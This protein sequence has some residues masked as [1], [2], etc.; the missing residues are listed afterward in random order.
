[1]AEAYYAFNQE[2]NNYYK[3]EKNYNETVTFGF[4]FAGDLDF[5]LY[6]PVH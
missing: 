3:L 4:Q 5:F 2:Y 6:N 1:M